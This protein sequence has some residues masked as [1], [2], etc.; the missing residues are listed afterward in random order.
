MA[1]WIWNLLSMAV[2]AGIT[3]AVSRRYLQPRHSD[4]DQLV[5]ELREDLAHLQRIIVAFS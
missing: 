2:S 3:W 5:E 4:L 1:T